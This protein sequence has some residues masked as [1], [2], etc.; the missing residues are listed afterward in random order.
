MSKR[1]KVAGL[2]GMCGVL[3]LLWCLSAGA[4]NAAI[5]GIRIDQRPLP[6]QKT[7]TADGQM[8]IGDQD[9]CP[10]CAMFPAKRPQTAAAMVLSDGRTFYFCGNG[11][12]LRAWHASSVYLNA[13]QEKIA[14]LVT[15]DFF[16][17][18]SIDARKAWWV[19]G[20][21]VVGPMGPALVALPSEAEVER[22]KAQ[23]GGKLVFQLAQMTPELW[24]QIFGD[25]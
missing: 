14:R 23:H 25:R 1:K 22:F 18:Q 13:P 2:F 10:V 5:S 16:S 6:A 7:L 3:L 21:D 11:C 20:S 8:Q 17:G 24:S 15:R 4:D 9:R 19:A 12:L